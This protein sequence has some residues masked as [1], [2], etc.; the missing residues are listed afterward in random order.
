LIIIIFV[1]EKQ[2]VDRVEKNELFVLA[3]NNV[4]LIIFDECH[5][6]SGDNQYAALM[7]K[8]Y[9]NCFDPPRILGLTA[10]LSTKKIKPKDLPDDAKDLERIYR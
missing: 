9:D 6:A 1:R 7:N 5:H 3:L 2:N 10:S 8:H 4:N